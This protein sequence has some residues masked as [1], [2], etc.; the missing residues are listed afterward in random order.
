MLLI[1][2]KTELKG[3]VVL[4]VLMTSHDEIVMNENSDKTYSLALLKHI[5]ADENRHTHT[6]LGTFSSA[7]RCYKVFQ[8]IV[9]SLKKGKRTFNIPISDAQQIPTFLAPRPSLN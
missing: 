3:Y 2:P 6:P 8:S 7:D 1:L 9:E 5:D 4:G